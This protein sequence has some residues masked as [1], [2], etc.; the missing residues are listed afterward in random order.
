M[1]F[2][3]GTGEE[4]T[5]LIIEKMLALAED[6]FA[7]Q[8]DPGQIPVN[9]ETLQ[10]LRRLHSATILYRLEDGEFVSWVISLPTQ[11]FLME[12]F[13]EGAITE[14]ELLELTKPEDSYEALYLCAAFTV[15]AHRRKGYVLGLFAEALR[16]LP[17]TADAPLFA[18]PV[19]Y[20]GK[21]IAE[22]LHHLLPRLLL[23]KE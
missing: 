17:L 22:K 15:A 11:R 21:M 20:E 23:I 7:T 5:A 2:L 19:S 6:F 9:E 18:W 8:N 13:L 14:R 10:K 16:R 4:L 12:Q 1:D 3:I